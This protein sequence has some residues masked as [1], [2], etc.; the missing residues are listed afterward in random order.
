LVLGRTSA[1]GKAF[2][3]IM[4]QPHFTANQ[5]MLPI[6]T[7]DHNVAHELHAALGI[8]APQ[9]DQRA[10]EREPSAWSI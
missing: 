1:Q 9:V 5:A 10:S 8:D 3:L 6:G 2:D 7:D 4:I